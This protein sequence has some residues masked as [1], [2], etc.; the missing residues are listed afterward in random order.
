VRRR[1]TAPGDHTQDAFALTPDGRTLI[2]FRSVPRPGRPWFE[3]ELHALDVAGGRDRVVTTLVMGFENRPGLSPIALDPAGSRVA[4]TGPPSELGSALRGKEPNAFASMLWVTDLASGRSRC[5]TA[6]LP[7]TVEARLHWSGDGRRITFLGNHGARPLLHEIDVDTLACPVVDLGSEAVSDADVS[8]DGATV[9]WVGSATDRL[10]ALFVRRPG[11]AVRDVPYFDPNTDLRRRFALTA[12]GAIA[13]TAADGKTPIEGWLYRPADA[14]PARKTPLV[15]YYYGG[16]TPTMLGWD[17]LH[18]MLA[19][20]GYA[21]LVLNPRGSGGYGREFADQHVAEWGELA[22]RDILA[23]LDQ[24]LARETWIDSGKVGCYGGSYGGFMTLWL[25][26]HSDRFAAAVPMFAISN[27][28]SYF[29]DGMW[30][31]TYGDQ[32]LANTYP[33]SKPGWFTEHSPLFR[34]DHIR[35]PVLLLHGDADRNVPPGESEQMF[36][37]LKLLGRD[38]ELVRFPGEDHGLGGTWTDRALHRTMLLEWFDRWLKGA[39]D[40]WKARWGKG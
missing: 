33:W 16:A 36:T 10:P 21:V 35:T 13:L 32:A 23:A 30:G 28:A 3:S 4:W 27:L 12:P 15:V 38:V 24:V 8:A 7:L 25:V 26:S 29:G 37:A 11:S 39:P 2:F 1:I 22:G 17:A 6:D 20:N 19:A 5:L 34:A 9:A 18:T 31:W 14:D 40:A